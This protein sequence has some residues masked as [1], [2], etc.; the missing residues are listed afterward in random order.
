MVAPYF[1]PA[2]GADSHRVRA[3]LPYFLRYG[4]NAE[5]LAVRP[6]CLAVPQDPWMRE[7]IPDDIRVHECRALS[8]RWS[9]LP[10]LGTIDL[11]AYGGM[12]R[13]GDRLL[14]SR[15][16]DLVYFSTTAFGLTALGPR[17]KR[18]F[19]VPFVVDYQDPWITDYY[20]HHREVKPPGGRIKYS[21]VDRLARLRE[22]VV[23][24]ACS[25]ITAVSP[26][27]RD[28]LKQRYAFCSEMP[29]L[30]VPFPGA[31]R[32]FD[33]VQDGSVVQRVFDP[34][35]GNLHWVC[36]GVSGAIMYRA[37]EAFFLAL[38][39]FR[40]REPEIAKKLRM[41]FIGTSYAPAGTGLPVVKPLAD[42][43]G[44]A[45][46]VHEQTDRI[47]YS[48]AL[49]CLLDADAI[50]VTGSDDP[51]YNASKLLPNLMARKPLLAVVHGRSAIRSMI[52]EL[53]GATLVTFDDL[54][55]PAATAGRTEH[56]WFDG[57]KY[58]Q[59]VGLSDSAL[60]RYMDRSQ[61]GLLCEFFTQVSADRNF[62]P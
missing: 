9:R 7:G 33:R 11:R 20:Q 25:G 38:A 48:T 55:S 43:L 27:Y 23:L 28:Q 21:I 42:R 53:R 5:V 54:D 30:I 31:K 37:L 34:N 10:G 39:A 56:A 44:V 1:P 3:T 16:F 26:A 45:Q 50:L 46:L 32:D 52:D 14:G 18:R 58:E 19:G 62:A 6:E 29:S 36:V 40:Q 59:T 51:T 4:W 47:P 49:C 13:A 41:H 22:P 15:R 60:E 24:R 17:W 61:A 8:L 57:A 12:K 2:N 35:D